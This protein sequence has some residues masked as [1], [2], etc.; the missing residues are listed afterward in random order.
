[1]YTNYIFTFHGPNKPINPLVRSNKWVTVFLHPV[2]HISAILKLSFLLWFQALFFCCFLVWLSFP[3]CH[4]N[5]FAYCLLF[6]SHLFRDEIS[7]R[8]CIPP[9]TFQILLSKVAP[10]SLSS[11][12]Q[13]LRV[14]IQSNF[15]LSVI[16]I[17]CISLKRPLNLCIKTGYPRKS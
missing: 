12:L 1:M 15:L 16:I 8:L 17:H 4:P 10:S 9:F 11:H 2:P 3:S 7:F 5:L 13:I 14:L 6:Y